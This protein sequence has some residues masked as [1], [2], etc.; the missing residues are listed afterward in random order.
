MVEEN[1][2]RPVDQPSALLELLQR[3]AEA[4]EFEEGRV[5]RVQS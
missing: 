3:G 4:L 5:Q 2:E 1:E